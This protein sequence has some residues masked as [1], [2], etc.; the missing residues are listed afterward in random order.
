[1]I[2]MNDTNS[3]ENLA[4]SHENP[5]SFTSLKVNADEIDAISQEKIV[6]KNYLI[7]ILLGIVIIILIIL[8]FYFNLQ[9]ANLKQQILDVLVSRSS[10]QT[11]NQ[12]NSNSQSTSNSIS[13]S[14]STST[15]SNF[16]SNS[17]STNSLSGNS[18]TNLLNLVD[19]TNSQ[20]LGVSDEVILQDQE[21]NL[22]SDIDTS[23]SL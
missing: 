2:H 6:K 16:S 7:S 20:I 3:P 9:N 21:K 23:P 18:G 1:M 22:P 14:S 11:S 12:S 17:S 4:I 10:S 5:N 8:I 19:Q 15:S 13:S